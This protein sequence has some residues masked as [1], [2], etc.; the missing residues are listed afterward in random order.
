MRINPE[1]FANALEAGN[2]VRNYA[3][4]GNRILELEPGEFDLSGP[5]RKAMNW[6]IPQGTKI[7]M[8]EFTTLRSDAEDVGDG[9]CFQLDDGVEILGGRLQAKLS[10]NKHVCCVGIAGHAR[11]LGISARVKGTTILGGNFQV[12]LWD[13]N[14]VGCD[15]AFED[16]LILGGRWL[17]TNGNSGGNNANRMTLL[18]CML[19]GD[20][21]LGYS[22]PASALGARLHGISG[23]GGITVVRGGMINLVGAEDATD[24]RGAWTP[25]AT[26]PPGRQSDYEGG[27]PEAL[28]DLMGVD[29]RVHGGG[30]ANAE[31]VEQGV[32]RIVV[33]GGSQM[34]L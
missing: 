21:A 17:V 9:C 30:A 14:A 12:Y 33:S 18:D 8:H 23:R 32:G 27:H 3:K 34:V 11:Y 5:I 19:D 31:P 13:E 26:S 15:V 20:F 7:A 16:C 1:S 29:I 24:V 2:F 22:D 4:P 6:H 25:L 28:I 10:S